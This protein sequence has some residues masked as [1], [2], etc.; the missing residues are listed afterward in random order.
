MIEKAIKALKN[1]KFVLLYDFGNRENEVDMII[2]CEFVRPEHVATMRTFAGGLICVSLH[3][4]IARNLGL[5]YLTEIYKEAMRKF[6]ILKLAWPDDIP[7]DE[8]SAFS[9]TVNHRRT[10]TGITDTDRALTIRELGRIARKAMRR[11]AMEE[12]GKNFRSPGH[13]HILKAADGLLEERKGHTELS[14][15]LSEMAGI[16]PAIAICEV[17]DARTKK[18]AGLKKAEKMARTLKTVLVSGKEVEIA[19]RETR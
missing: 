16:T 4:K 19:W 13:V 12:F 14:I 18:A 3:P 17:L 10:F 15:A 9:V 8:K 2:P 11:N 7:Y 1:G 5:P 6:R